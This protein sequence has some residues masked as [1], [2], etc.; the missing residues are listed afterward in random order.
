MLEHVNFITKMAIE[1]ERPLTSQRE[2]RRSLSASLIGSASLLAP[3][4]IDRIQRTSGASHDAPQTAHLSSLISARSYL[5]CSLV[6]HPI[7]RA[8]SA[9]RAHLTTHLKRRTYLSPTTSASLSR[10]TSDQSRTAHLGRI[11]YDAPRSARLSQ[12]DHIR[13]AL[14]RHTHQPSSIA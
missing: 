8:Y 2:S 5:H 12:L 1:C 7:N 3:H 14:S 9:P 6:P 13:I 11:S 4:P 10:T